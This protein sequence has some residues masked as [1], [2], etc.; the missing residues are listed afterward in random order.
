MQRP[1]EHRGLHLGGRPIAQKATVDGASS[2][3]RLGASVLALFAIFQWSAAALGSDRGQAG[4][5]VCALVVGATLLCER[6]LFAK[7]TA[8]ATEA[9][10]LG[11][12]RAIG[13]AAATEIAVLL[14]MVVPVFLAVTRS[15]SPAAEHALPPAWAVYP[16]RH[17]RRNAVPRL[18]L[19]PPAQR[20]ILL[21]GPPGSRCSP[22]S[23]RI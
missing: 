18:P 7:T 3:I 19:R 17:R 15:S 16:G 8:A 11:R 4:V 22:S 21:A 10:G 2:W 5:I 23:P 1:V 6:A 9:I 20:P 13:L 12:P 14:L